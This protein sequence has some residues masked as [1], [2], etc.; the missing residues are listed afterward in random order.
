VRKA[1]SSKGF[2]LPE[3]LVALA[4][5]G[6]ASTAL[7]ATLLTNVCSN[8]ISNEI[9]KATRAQ[10]WIEYV[11]AQTMTDAGSKPVAEGISN[12]NITVTGR[13]YTITLSGRSELRDPI[14]GSWLTRNLQTTRQ[15]RNS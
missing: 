2:S 9:S 3:V 4:V 7:V 11:C 15:R 13:Q 12:M 10:N 14:S 1:S 5:L 6:I 8:R